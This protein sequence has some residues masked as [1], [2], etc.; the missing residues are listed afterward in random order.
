L[1]WEGLSG[2]GGGETRSQRF[3]TT[4]DRVDAPPPPKK[5]P[6]PARGASPLKPRSLGRRASSASALAHCM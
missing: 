4:K 2:K 5:R 3:S 6:A 1:E